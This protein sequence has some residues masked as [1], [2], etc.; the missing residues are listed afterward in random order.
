MSFEVKGN[1]PAWQYDDASRIRELAV[2]LYEKMYDKKPTVTAIHA[3]LECGFIAEKCPGIDMISL[4]P[5]LQ[6]IHSPEERLSISS[7]Q[8]VYEYILQLLENLASY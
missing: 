2:S 3:G 4:G 5:D 6:Y 8:R 1:Y 7:T